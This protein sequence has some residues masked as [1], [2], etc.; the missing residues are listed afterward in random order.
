ME[1]LDSEKR[2]WWI[3]MGACGHFRS[4]KIKSR[5]PPAGEVKNDKWQSCIYFESAD[6]AKKFLRLLKDFILTMYPR[7][8]SE[9]WFL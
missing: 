9:K 4:L 1:S 5:I 8:K 3:T 6:D 7:A 2:Y